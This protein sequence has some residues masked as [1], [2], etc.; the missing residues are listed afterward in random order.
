MKTNK[1]LAMWDCY[2][3]ECIF[4]ITDLEHDSLIATLK[5]QEFKAPFNISMLMMRARVNN[6]RAYEIYSFDTDLSITQKD[7]EDQFRNNPQ[8]IVDLIRQ[9]GRMIFSDR[10]LKK[11]VIT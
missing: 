8:G 11:A 3:L 6:Q 7:I 1:F 10:R 9:Q 2:G 5:G 4:D